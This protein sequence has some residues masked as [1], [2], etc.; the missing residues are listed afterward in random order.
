MTEETPGF[1]T[2][3][4]LPR[5]EPGQ[6]V[7]YYC[8]SYVERRFNELFGEETPKW[9]WSRTVCLSRQLQRNRPPEN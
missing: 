2:R 9:P 3:C 1:C 8:M 6:M 7:C 5:T 4:R